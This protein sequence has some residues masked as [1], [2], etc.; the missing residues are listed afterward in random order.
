MEQLALG[1]LERHRPIEV[2]PLRGATVEHIVERLRDDIVSRRLAA[3]AHLVENDLTIRFAVSRGPVREA[4]RRLA[5]EGLVDQFPHRGAWVR[6]RG[7]HELR[8][9]F[10]IFIELQSLAA[11]LAAANGDPAA[12]SAFE[13]AI[14]RAQ[15]GGAAE[16]DEFTWENN[17]F[18]EAALALAGSG[19][20]LEVTRRLHLPL[21]LARI[22]DAIGGDGGAP[23]AASERRAI[24][25]AILA[26]DPQAAGA[27]MRAHLTAMLARLAD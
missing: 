10:Q 27:G 15:D 8:E 17:A 25:A 20:L 9:L 26:G 18:H 6:K 23:D 13:R 16:N 12:R 3:G 1:V 7:R 19:Q 24:A 11:Q 2:P 4:L 5:A 22:G 21:L 14:A